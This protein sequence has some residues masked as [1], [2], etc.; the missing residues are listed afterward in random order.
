VGTF[1][2]AYANCIRPRAGEVHGIDADVS[3]C[4]FLAVVPEASL[5]ALAN[6][7]YGRGGTGGPSTPV[8]I[9][10][11]A[12][13][14]FMLGGNATDTADVGAARIRPQVAREVTT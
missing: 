13:N 6:G 5:G 1:P 4:G 8:T 11:G 14:D 2:R 7:I 12:G 9:G 10:I 3:L